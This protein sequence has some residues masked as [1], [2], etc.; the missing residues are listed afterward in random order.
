MRLFIMLT[1]VEQIASPRPVPPKRRV[2]E[3]SAW[4]NAS[5]IAA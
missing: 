5:K 2:V 4:R 1:S 3:P